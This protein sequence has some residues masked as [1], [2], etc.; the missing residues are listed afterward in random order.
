[1]DK[2]KPL[3]AGG[4]GGAGGAGGAG[5]VAGKVGIRSMGRGKGDNKGEDWITV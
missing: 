5:A 3:G 4:V 1:M 2:C